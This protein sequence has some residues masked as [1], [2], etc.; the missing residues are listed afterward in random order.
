MARRGREEVI[1]FFFSS[2]IGDVVMG[3]S[4][5][6]VVVVVPSL[7]SAFGCDFVVLLSA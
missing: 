4:Y 2:L 7:F 5:K 6:L 1:F 3:V